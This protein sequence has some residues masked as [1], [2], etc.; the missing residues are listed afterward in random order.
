[1][2]KPEKKARRTLTLEEVPPVPPDTPFDNPNGDFVFS[3]VEADGERRWRFTAEGVC[4]YYLRTQP[5]KGRGVTP[6]EEMYRG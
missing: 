5:G 4:K 3:T 6:Y 1:M 2:A